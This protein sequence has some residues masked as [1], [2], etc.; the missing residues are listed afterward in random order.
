MRFRRTPC[1]RIRY[2]RQ[3]P[4]I[5]LVCPLRAVGTQIGNDVSQNG[6]HQHRQGEIRV[7]HRHPPSPSA[8]STPAGVSSVS[9]SGMEKRS[10]ASP[11]DPRRS[12]HP[13]NPDPFYDSCT[14]D[15]SSISAK[16]LAVAATEAP[17][18]A[19]NGRA[20]PHQSRTLPN[21]RLPVSRPR[22][23]C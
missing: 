1:F 12:S 17:D 22:V 8:S 15:L 16:L 23:V 19:A 10:N 13:A 20:L 21:P 9:A 5:C 7:Q 11:F 14:H 3:N 4:F 18:S 2:G 6:H